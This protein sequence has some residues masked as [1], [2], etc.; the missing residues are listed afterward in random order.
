MSQ[1]PPEDVVG[2]NV[3]L[4]PIS[5][6]PSSSILAPLWGKRWGTLPYPAQVTLY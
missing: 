3:P 2:G 5:M 1:L 4:Y 6:H